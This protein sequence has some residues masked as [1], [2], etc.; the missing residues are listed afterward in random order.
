MRRATA[1]TWVMLS[2]AA[3]PLSAQAQDHDPGHGGSGGTPATTG[4]HLVAIANRAY[5]PARLTMLVGDSVTWRN[6]DFVTHNVSASDGAVLSGAL[7]RGERFSHSFDVVGGH[8]YVCTIHS[9]M[10]GRVDVYGALLEAASGSVLVGED[11]QLHGRAVAGSGP[12][13]IEQP[14]AGTAGFT[15]VTTVS[16]GGDGAFHT[17]VHPS[18]PMDYRAVTAAGASPPVTVSVTSKLI[19][20]VSAHAGKRFTRLRVTARGAGAATAG[21]QL[22]SRERFRWIETQRKR[23]DDSGRA[24]FRLR[25]GLRY[26]ARAVVTRAGG[27]GVLGVSARVKLPR[28][29]ASTGR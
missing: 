2:V 18:G 24:D 6:D 15:P 3:W 23:L 21:I 22:Y 8:S 28:R 29:A 7:G 17:S 19:V 9:F 11:I 14:P 25:A 16:P 26:H 20:R 13:T 1:M 5:S 27:E 4:S 12:V 10:Q